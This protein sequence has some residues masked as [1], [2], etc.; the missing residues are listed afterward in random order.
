MLLPVGK[1]PALSSGFPFQVLL[2]P[3]K[4]LR[5]FT[6]PAMGGGAVLWGLS[7]R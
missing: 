2:A 1:K 5:P 6:L 7:A 4:D 3:G